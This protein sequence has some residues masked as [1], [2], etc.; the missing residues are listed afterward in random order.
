MSGGA[1]VKAVPGPAKACW[2]SAQG[3]R[4]K[5]CC[6]KAA[7]PCSGV[8]KPLPARRQRRRGRRALAAFCGEAGA[9]GFAADAA[10]GAAGA[11]VEAAAVGVDAGDAT[12]A[13]DAAVPPWSTA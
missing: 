7:T 5:C 3:R 8:A 13:A 6:S 9:V 10:V 4:T 2:N 12:P 11:G 1:P